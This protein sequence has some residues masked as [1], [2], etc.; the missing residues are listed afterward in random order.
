MG[1]NNDNFALRALTLASSLPL[2]MSLLAAYMSD[3]GFRSEIDAR[4]PTAVDLVYRMKATDPSATAVEALDKALFP[5]TATMPP[6]EEMARWGSGDFARIL[7]P[8]LTQAPLEIAVVGALEESA[9]IEAVA[10][11]FGA[12][13]RRD[14]TPRTAEVAFKRFPAALPP[15][16]LAHHVGPADKAAAVLVWPLY[17]ATPERRKEEYAIT[18]LS[19][20]LDGALRQ[21]LRVAMGKTYAPAV[22]NDMPDDADQGTMVAAIEARPED[23]DAV[24]KAARETAASLAAGNI[25]QEAFESARQPLLARHAEQLRSNA[26]WAEVLAP[27]S[28]EP[29]GLID[30]AEYDAIVSALTLEDVKRAAAEWLKG[31]PAVARSLPATGKSV[32]AGGSAR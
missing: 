31:E 19:A 23:L 8:A 28:H 17:V 29:Q 27:S 24:I 12:L 30:L 6:P 15:P 2:E 16:V 20:V 22:E 25:S 5:G 9:A 1:I 26:L 7:K 18:V 11:T 21:R 13:P 10:Q 14:S 3:P 32:A 4:L